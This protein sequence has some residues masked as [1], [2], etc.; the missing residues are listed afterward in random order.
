MAGSASRIPHYVK[1]VSSDELM[2]LMLRQNLND[3]K[4]YSYQIAYSTSEK[5][6]YAWFYKEVDLKKQLNKQG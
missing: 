2:S 6:W 4:E 3:G 5:S 1:A